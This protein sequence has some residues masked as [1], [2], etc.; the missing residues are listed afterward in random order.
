MRSVVTRLF[1][2][3]V[4]W[5][6]GC[7]APLPVAFLNAEEPEI[8]AAVDRRAVPDSIVVCHGYGCGIAHRIALQPAEWS[9]IRALFKSVTSADTERRA[10]SQAVG[11]F[12]QGA[13]RLLGTSRDLPRSPFRINDPTQLD[14]VDE[15][16]NTSSFLHLLKGQGL[17]HWHA[18]GEPARRR[19]FLMFGIHFTAVLIENQ[20]GRGYAV[21]SWFHANGVPAEVVELERWR[22]GWEPG[23]AS[24]SAERAAAR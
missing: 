13:G 4:A 2:L 1:A 7:A 8:S 15:T 9:D 14:C 5:L 10:I 19:S 24:A 17:L 11:L 22:A 21:D 18:V 3:G 6:A 20:G 23:S 16:I 12:E